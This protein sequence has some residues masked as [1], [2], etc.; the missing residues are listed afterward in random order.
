MNAFLLPM[1]IREQKGDEAV[2]GGVED[3]DE[4]MP[5]PEASGSRDGPRVANESEEKNVSVPSGGMEMKGEARIKPKEILLDE[6]EETGAEK[7]LLSREDPIRGVIS[8][9]FAPSA[10][11]AIGFAWLTIM[12][13]GSGSEAWAPMPFALALADAA[14]SSYNA[15]VFEPLMVSSSMPLRITTSV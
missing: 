5:H 4:D 11:R 9:V 3:P 8:C 6:P 12:T 7:P 13:V 10:L 15:V 14:C 1:R 2:I